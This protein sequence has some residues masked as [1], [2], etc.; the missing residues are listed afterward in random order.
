MI[1][2]GSIGGIY[3]K[4]I[5]DMF[6]EIELIGVCDLVREKAEKAKARADCERAALSVK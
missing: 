1:G 2:V 3:L 4:N 5:R 6:R